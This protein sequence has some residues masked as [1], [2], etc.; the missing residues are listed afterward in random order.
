MD[1]SRRQMN[2]LQL[3]VDEFVST[4]IEV[5]SAALARRQRQRRLSPA[6]IR[7][8]LRKLEEAGLLMRRRANAGCLP[9]EEGLRS[10]LDASLNPKMH[11]W[12][13]QHLDD[14]TRGVDPAEIRGDLKN[15]EVENSPFP[16]Q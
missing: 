9:T 2:L 16:I 3:V 4:G 12:D 1:L 7:N 5:S 14:A 15:T 10:Y 11:P 13:R 8:E 6:T